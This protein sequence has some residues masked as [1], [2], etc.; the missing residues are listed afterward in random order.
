MTEDDLFMAVTRDLRKNIH[1]HAHNDK[2]SGV[3]RL[4][5]PQEGPRNDKL[6]N[7]RGSLV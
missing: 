4:L 5:L 1:L 3:P 7:L 2:T 6:L